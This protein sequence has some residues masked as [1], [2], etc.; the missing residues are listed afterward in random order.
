M[1]V[2]HH[3]IL[4]WLIV[5]GIFICLAGIRANNREAE[6]RRNRRRY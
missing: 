5:N 1:S 3:I 2:L 6:I 4:P